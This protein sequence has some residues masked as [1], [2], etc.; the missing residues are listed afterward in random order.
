MRLK[1]GEP[2]FGGIWAV[3][4]TRVVSWGH[5]WGRTM[6]LLKG[7]NSPSSTHTADLGKEKEYMG[8]GLRPGVL[9]VDLAADNQKFSNGICSQWK[10]VSPA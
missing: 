7:A 9:R 6:F 10:D 3:A 8:L 1:A 5:Y 2:R 4:L